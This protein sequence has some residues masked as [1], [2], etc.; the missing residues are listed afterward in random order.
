MSNFFTLSGY[1]L[2]LKTIMKPEWEKDEVG[3]F[4]AVARCTKAE[5][6]QTRILG[7][8]TGL[9]NRSGKFFHLQWLCFQP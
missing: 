3:I 1:F 6:N 2:I 5:Q 7:I 9:N 8:T 4:R